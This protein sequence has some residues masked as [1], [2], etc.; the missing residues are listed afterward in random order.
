MSY[1]LPK[2]WYCQFLEEDLKTPIPRKVTLDDPQKPIEMVER[3]GGLPNS[4][5]DQMLR[6]SIELGRGGAWLSLTEEQYPKL[7]KR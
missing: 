6:Y 4:E 5:A 1:L 2:S 7:R 3:G